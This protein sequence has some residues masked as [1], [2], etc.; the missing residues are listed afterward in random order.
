MNE[1]DYRL[2]SRG[3]K[4][5]SSEQVAFYNLNLEMESLKFSLSP[6][7]DLICH[8]IES[9]YKGTCRISFNNAIWWERETLNPCMQF[10]DVCIK[11][12]HIQRGSEMFIILGS[13]LARILLLRLLATPLI[14]DSHGLLFSSTEKGIFSFILARLLFDLKNS[15]KN[16]MPDLKL[17]NIYHC[18][19]DIHQA[20]NI[21][22]F[23]FYNFTLTFAAE[24]YPVM[25]CLP[26]N[27]F[28][29][30]KQQKRRDRSLFFRCGHVKR[31]LIFRL[32]LIHLTSA[33]LNKLS[34]GDLIIFNETSKAVFQGTFEG[35]ICGRWDNLWVYGN[36]KN[37]NERYLFITSGAPQIDRGEKFLMEDID[38]HE[39]AQGE[40]TSN[41]MNPLNDGIVASALKDVKI[42]LSIEI[43]RIPMSLGAI[44]QIRD[45][46]IIDLNRK[47]DDP[48]E[49]VLEDKVI[50]YCQ[51]VQ[52][53][54][55]LGIRVLRMNSE[56]N[57]AI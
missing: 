47:I 50:G 2:I 19:E 28:P 6:I 45:G 27:I 41:N 13:R 18:Q 43:S 10:D 48:L 24:S 35:A 46:E 34:F 9:I 55:R 7:I 30:I 17:I 5:L 26:S 21:N 44:S 11:F 14:D 22:N 37:N 52:I 51:P 38:L 29:S 8:R 53:N 56:E 16:Q 3:S 20:A 40:N 54:G 32:A 25:L 49:M 31:M 33:T 15:L 1:I 42:S 36:I 4:D 39:T 57:L 12:L 23:G